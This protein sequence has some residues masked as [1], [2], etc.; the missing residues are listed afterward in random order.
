MT[1]SFRGLI[2]LELFSFFQGLHPRIVTEGFEVAKAKALQVSY[3]LW[4]L[5]NLLDLSSHYE[6]WYLMYRIMVIAINYG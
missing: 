3:A 6:K 2:N 1:Q 5:G 4:I